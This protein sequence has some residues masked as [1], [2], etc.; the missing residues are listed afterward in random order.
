MPH[1]KAHDLFISDQAFVEQEDGTIKPCG[2]V[3]LHCESEHDWT[4]IT[5]YSTGQ[6]QDCSETERYLHNAAFARRIIKALALLDAHEMCQQH[7][8]TLPPTHNEQH[9]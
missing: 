4:T 3:D 7:L 6:A 5:L 9:N 1:P 8:G 2:W